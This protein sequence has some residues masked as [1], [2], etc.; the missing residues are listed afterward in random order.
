MKSFALKTNNK[1]VI[2]YLLNNFSYPNTYIS[3]KKFKIY[4]NIIFHY[5]GKYPNLFI[6]ELSNSLVNAIIKFKES[7]ILERII[8]TNYFYFSE[9]E[10]EIVLKK[11][12]VFLNDST[13]LEHQVRIEH[14]YVAFLKY[15]SSNKS[16]ILDGFINFRLYNYI[17][18]L[19]YVV[20][21]FINDFVIDRE[22]KE[23]INLLKTYVNS[24]PCNTNIVHFIYKEE[25]SKL[26]DGNYKEIPL[27]SD[28]SNLNY[29]SDVSFSENDI[30]LN[31]LLTI[32]PRKI[33]IHLF[34]ESDEFIKTLICI[35]ENRVE[36]SNSGLENGPKIPF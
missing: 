35:F 25:N 27:K 18:L 14:L 8:K 2:N 31:T 33:I 29:I 34:K 9:T 36:F 30:S 7:K 13:N 20:D 10:Q 24:K 22:Y 16:V 17:K 5:K 23:F 3:V 6:G 28:I 32:L 1:E 26:L 15:I 12:L 19:D 4:T 21:I 11:C